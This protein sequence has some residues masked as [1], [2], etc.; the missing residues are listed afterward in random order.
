MAWWCQMAW[1]D[2][3]SQLR[4]YG[5]ASSLFWQ[6]YC[7]SF[8]AR[9]FQSA[10]LLFWNVWNSPF[11]TNIYCD[12][13]EMTNMRSMANT[14]GHAACWTSDANI[15]I[16]KLCFLPIKNIIL[17]RYSSSTLSD[18]YSRSKAYSFSH[19]DSETHTHTHTFP[20]SSQSVRQTGAG[21]GENGVVG[22]C[23]SNFEEPW[24]SPGFHLNYGF[25][26]IHTCHVL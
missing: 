24:Y 17:L 2:Y 12:K 11:S 21:E 7:W 6:R 4:A 1:S 19:T 9:Y 23:E 13:Y 18:R 16:I 14:A 5:T 10:V 25:I 20:Q 8:T 15:S 22:R 3:W 26:I